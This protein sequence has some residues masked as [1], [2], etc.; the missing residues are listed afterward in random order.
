MNH[1]LE[2]IKE[3]FTDMNNGQVMCKNNG[4]D[5][6]PI[7]M[8][9]GQQTRDFFRVRESRCH[10]VNQIFM[11]ELLFHLRGCEVLW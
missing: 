7:E 1:G 4:I 6:E 3:L 9:F 8:S 11:V 2:V 5:S 10:M